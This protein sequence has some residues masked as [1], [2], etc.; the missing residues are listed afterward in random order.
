MGQQP[1]RMRIAHHAMTWA[2]WWKQQGIA[3]DTPRFF[4]E[5]REAGYEGVEIGG[6]AAVFGPAATVARQAAEAGVA[7]AAVATSVTL[8]P[9]APNTEAY[10]RA[11]DYA[12]ELGVSM[13]MVCGGFHWIKRRNMLDPEYAMFAGNLAEAQAYAS[14]HGQTVAFH[15]HVGCI[16][17]TNAEVD[18]LLR[19]V[20]DLKLC[21]DTGHSIAVGSDPAELVRRYPGKVVHVHLKDWIVDEESF[22]ELGQGRSPL[23]FAAF[24]AALRESGYSGWIVVERDGP[25]VEGKESARISREFLRRVEPSL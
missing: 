2:G 4:A 11:M 22:T 19:F 17:E 21:V 20:P 8:N 5:A 9:H 18:R 14:R 24:F 13:V 25:K 7:L 3:F 16:A 6:D 23:D 10:R 15:P 12:A 1:N